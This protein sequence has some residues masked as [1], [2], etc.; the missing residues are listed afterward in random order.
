MYEISLKSQKKNRMIFFP[1]FMISV[2]GTALFSFSTGLYLLET[3]GKGF[4]YAMNIFLFT[5]PMIIFAPF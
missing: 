5:L 3:T 2:I 1:G 4:L